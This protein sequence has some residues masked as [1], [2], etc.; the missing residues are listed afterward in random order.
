M[1]IDVAFDR[2]AEV[3]EPV[4]TYGVVTIVETKYLDHYR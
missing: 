2:F 4:G 3:V 1:R